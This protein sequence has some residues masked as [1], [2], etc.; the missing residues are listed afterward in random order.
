MLISFVLFRLAI[1][2]SQIKKQY[3]QALWQDC[4]IIFKWRATP[5]FCQVVKGR[6]STEGIGVWDR[7][8]LQKGTWGRRQGCRRGY[9]IRG[10]LGEGG[11]C[12]LGHRLG[13][14]SP[15]GRMSAGKDSGLR[16]GL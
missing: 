7:D 9:G 5:R 10:S 13:V 2:L 11:D 8:S 1:P 15:G 14:Q 4:V 3:G 12:D 16:K 6:F